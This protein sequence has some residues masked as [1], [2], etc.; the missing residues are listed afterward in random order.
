MVFCCKNKKC[1]YSEGIKIYFLDIMMVD[2]Y[3]CRHG[4]TDKNLE[5]VW[6][7][8]GIDI[9]LN[10]TGE[11][12]ATELAEKLR[13][14]HFDIYSSPLIRAVQTANAIAG[15]RDVTVMQN[16]REGNFGDVEG[17]SFAKVNE[18]YGEDFVENIFYPT[19]ESADWHF[20]NAESKRQI[21][22]R[23]YDCLL[24]IVCYQTL[25]GAKHCACVVCH[26]GVISA[27][28]FGLKLINVSLENCAI[29]HLQYDTE[30]RQFVQIFD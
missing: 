27:L 11:K 3:I 24:R 9:P 15:K 7:G 12:Q 13:G 18:Q 6:Q 5:Q 29:L 21:F 19:E 30:L 16:L 2:F 25:A 14:K 4:Q 26:A 20:P 17:M 23:V 8:S 1:G 22:A 10:A 28:R